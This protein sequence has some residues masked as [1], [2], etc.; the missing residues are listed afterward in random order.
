M[1]L[2]FKHV[3]K[4]F[5][6]FMDTFL[7]KQIMHMQRSTCVRILKKSKKHVWFRGLLLTISFRHYC[8]AIWQFSN[9][10][11]PSLLLSVLFCFYLFKFSLSLAFCFLLCLHSSLRVCWKFRCDFYTVKYCRT[12][13]IRP[14]AV[15][16][17]QRTKTTEGRKLRGIWARCTQLPAKSSLIGWLL[18]Q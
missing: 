2:C 14:R 4:N 6:F 16:Q 5:T 17:I 15:R 1:I 7:N 9:V 10:F 13:L 3:W 8:K 18:R 11:F 12:T